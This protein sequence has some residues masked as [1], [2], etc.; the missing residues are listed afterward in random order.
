MMKKNQEENKQRRDELVE[1]L[2]IDLN[3]RMHQVSDGQRKRVQIMLALLKPFKLLLIDENTNTEY[4]NMLESNEEFMK[5]RIILNASEIYNI[6]EDI[7]ESNNLSDK[8]TEK[9]DYLLRMVRN[10]RE[11]VNAIEQ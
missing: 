5:D 6:V 8:L 7:G 10:W 1:L 2:E 4:I 3:W 11:S 9:R